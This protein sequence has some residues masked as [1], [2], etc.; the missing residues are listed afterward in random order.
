MDPESTPLDEIIA[1]GYTIPDAR[2]V[3]ALF[4]FTGDDVFKKIK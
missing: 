1:Y 3:L 2:D 4:D